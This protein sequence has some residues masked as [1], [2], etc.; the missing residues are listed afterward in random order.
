MAFAIKATRKLYPD[1]GALAR[2][3]G[4]T[5]LG[6]RRSLA[7]EDLVNNPGSPAAL[8]NA[9][10]MARKFS[11]VASSSEVQ[12]EEEV[13]NA[14]LKFTGEKIMDALWTEA[15]LTNRIFVCLW[16]F[17]QGEAACHLAVGKDAIGAARFCDGGPNLLRSWGEDSFCGTAADRRR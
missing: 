1:P 9:I 12:R 4:L 3:F 17:A 16:R 13:Q 5:V 11:A 15:H 6:A 10:D 7:F 14:A 8:D 2:E